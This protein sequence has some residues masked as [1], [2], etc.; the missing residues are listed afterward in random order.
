MDC[1]DSDRAVGSIVQSTAATDSKGM[2]CYQDVT[3][4]TVSTMCMYVC[5]W[6]TFVRY[7]V[8]ND[9]PDGDGGRVGVRTLDLPCLFAAHVNVRSA[10]S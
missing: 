7:V 1:T 5:V 8:C 10:P 4:V 6:C 9:V 3:C 2:N